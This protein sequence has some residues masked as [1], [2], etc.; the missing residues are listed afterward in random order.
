MT[1]PGTKRNKL[2]DDEHI[3]KLAVTLGVLKGHTVKEDGL[4]GSECSAI[5]GPFDII[6]GVKNIDTR[7]SFYLKSV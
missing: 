6:A 2:S 1:E 3:R 7:F 4:M 5:Q